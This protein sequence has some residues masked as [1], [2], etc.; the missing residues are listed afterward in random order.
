MQPTRKINFLFDE[1]TLS[2]LRLCGGSSLCLVSQELVDGVELS[3][4]SGVVKKRAE[5]KSVVI[6]RIILGVVGG[7]EGGALVSVDGIKV[8]EA[9]DLQRHQPAQW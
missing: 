8:E 5:V 4:P 6:W 9:L 7:R 3:R 2:S 1:F